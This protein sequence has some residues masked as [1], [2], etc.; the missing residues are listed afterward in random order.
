MGRW[1]AE[2]NHSKSQFRYPLKR[3][4]KLLL[5]RDVIRERVVHTS[6]EQAVGVSH[7]HVRCAASLTTPIPL[8][9]L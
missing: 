4:D 7:T 5:S 9:V 2:H 3:L 1:Q 8:E 6:S